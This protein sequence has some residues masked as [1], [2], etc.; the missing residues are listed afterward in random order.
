MGRKCKCIS[1]GKFFKNPTSLKTHYTKEH[2]G[3]SISDLNLIH[4]GKL[5]VKV[6]RDTE[7]KATKSSSKE[8][9]AKANQL[10]D[11]CSELKKPEKLVRT[12]C[13]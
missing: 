12:L 5:D 13:L 4:T 2:P 8:V 3:Q 7:A 1:C 10:C 6:L 9:K 11:I